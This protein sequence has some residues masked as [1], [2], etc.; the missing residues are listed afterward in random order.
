MS[1][2]IQCVPKLYPWGLCPQTPEVY[3][4]A[5]QGVTSACLA[6]KRKERRANV[7]PLIAPH[8]ALGRSSPLPIPSCGRFMVTIAGGDV[9]IS[10]GPNIRERNPPKWLK[11]S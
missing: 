6:A 3:A 9:K 4:L 7:T 5:N 11:Y 8:Y 10:G 1:R 2:K